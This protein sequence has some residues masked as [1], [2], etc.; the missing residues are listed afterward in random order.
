MAQAGLPA[1][2]AAARK[3][4]FH[5]RSLI[6]RRRKPQLPQPAAATAA[7]P[8]PSPA[9]PLVLLAELAAAREA[10]AASGSLEVITDVM[11]QAWGPL[12]EAE[13]PVPPQQQREVAACASAALYCR[14]AV[15]KTTGWALPAGQ[16]VPAGSVGDWLKRV[17]SSCMHA[18]QTYCCL[19]GPGEWL[20]TVRGGA[21]GE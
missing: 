4:F 1:L 6:D 17:E 3:K 19:D 16:S 10:A 9:I 12:M 11:L 14:D 8:L 18:M 13:L 21:G 5:E 20:V 2:D 7:P 15:V